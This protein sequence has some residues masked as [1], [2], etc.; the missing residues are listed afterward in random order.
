MT[1]TL[2]QA[3]DQG[4]EPAQFQQEL[5]TL[6]ESFLPEAP[7][8]KKYIGLGGVE[9]YHISKA[10]MKEFVDDVAGCKIINSNHVLLSH[11][12]VRIVDPLTVTTLLPPQHEKAELV[13]IEALAATHSMRTGAVQIFAYRV[14]QIASD[15]NV[16]RFYRPRLLNIAVHHPTKGD[17]FDHRVQRIFEGEKPQDVVEQGMFLAML[18]DITVNAET[19]LDQAVWLKHRN[20]TDPFWL[21]AG[22]LELIPSDNYSN[23]PTATRYGVFWPEGDE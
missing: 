16:R 17:V 23:V 19:V 15:P 20:P 12:P 13:A 11:T 9:T 2:E 8:L 22:T 18:R 3:I 21:V 14:C 5:D 10:E 4:T 6:F 1:T 7:W